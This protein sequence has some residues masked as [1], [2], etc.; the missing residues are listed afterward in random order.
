[1]IAQAAFSCRPGT[2]ILRNDERLVV[3]GN[4]T[5]NQILTVRFP[6]L[7]TKRLRYTAGQ[8][9]T[10]VDRPFVKSSTTNS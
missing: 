5:L 9:L 6:D 10:A 1:M 8:V 7:S 2:I 4:D 3:T